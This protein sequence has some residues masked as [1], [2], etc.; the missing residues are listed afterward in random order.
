MKEEEMQLE[1]LMEDHRGIRSNRIAAGAR[2]EERTHAPN[3]LRLRAPMTI[4]SL[5]TTVHPPFFSSFLI[6][7]LLML[8]PFFCGPSQPSFHEI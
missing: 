6:S 5:F 4:Q 8:I 2:I 7:F 3:G 1:R